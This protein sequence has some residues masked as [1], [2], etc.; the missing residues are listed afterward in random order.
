MVIE[1]GTG[2]W[3]C[4]QV[5]NELSKKLISVGLKNAENQQQDWKPL[6]LSC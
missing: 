3:R 4:G 2:I 5:E 1:A 6:Y